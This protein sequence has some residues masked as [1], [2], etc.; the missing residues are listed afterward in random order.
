MNNHWAIHPTSDGLINKFFF[1]FL[2]GGNT[3][4]HG[5]QQMLCKAKWD[6]K[7]EEA[8]WTWMLHSQ[9]LTSEP[10]HIR[11]FPGWGSAWKWP[12]F[13]IICPYAKVK[14]WR[15]FLHQKYLHKTTLDWIFNRLHTSKRKKKKE[16]A[17]NRLHLI[18]KEQKVD[19]KWMKMK[20][21]CKLSIMTKEQG[22]RRL[23]TLGWK[24]VLTAL[25]QLPS[26]HQG[27][28]LALPFHPRVSRLGFPQYIPSLR[29]S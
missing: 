24:R 17:N 8:L 28:C 27:W 6:I 2:V 29:A 14:F 21:K 3:L 15:I 9:K 23:H 11:I 16:E 18:S 13:K 20:Q 1:F 5:S 19:R 22:Q 4:Y 10:L 26:Y 7:L 12:L 25:L